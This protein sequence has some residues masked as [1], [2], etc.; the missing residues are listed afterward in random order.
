VKGC[1]E[2]AG[3]RGVELGKSPEK[4]CGTNKTPFCLKI[5]S[6]NIF[7]VDGGVSFK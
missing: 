3:E 6:E 5:V 2:W 7:W 1:S 4:K